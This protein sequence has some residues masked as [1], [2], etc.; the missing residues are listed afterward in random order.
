[1][2]RQ[3]LVISLM[4]ASAVS[5]AAC[6]GTSAPNNT[7]P[8]TPKTSPTAQPTATAT[9]TN[10]NAP[11]TDGKADGVNAPV[12]PTDKS[13]TDAPKKPEDPKIALSSEP[14]KNTNAKPAASPKK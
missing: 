1:M 14:A 10:V 5:M 6:G 2:R 7:V 8:T 9:P 4:T 3:L 11:K 13:K 12:N